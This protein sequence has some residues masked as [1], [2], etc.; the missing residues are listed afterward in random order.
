MCCSC[1]RAVPAEERNQGRLRRVA[2]FVVKEPEKPVSTTRGRKKEED[3]K[4][5]R[6]TAVG[7]MKRLSRQR[8]HANHKKGARASW[9]SIVILRAAGVKVAQAVVVVGAR[10]GIGPGRGRKETGRVEPKKISQ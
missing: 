9:P 6:R 4:P 7:N 8:C 10:R 3:L 2:V 1:W 5:R